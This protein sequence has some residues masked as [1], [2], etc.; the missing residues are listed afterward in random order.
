[1]TEALMSAQDISGII[2]TI[3]DEVQKFATANE[4]IAN[5]TNLLALNAT[6]EAARAGEYGKG[7]AVVASEVKQLAKQA[8]GNSK[9]FRN[10]VLKKISSQTDQLA[11]QFRE[12]EY[13]RL[14][15]MAQTLVQ[16]IVRNLYERTA[17]VRWWATDESL[18]HCLD[19]ITPEKVEHATKRM[20]LI[21]RFYSVYLNLLLT[22]PAGKVIAV[23]RPDKFPMVVGADVSSHY[24]FKG[25]INTQRGDEYV[26]DEI[27]NDPLHGGA[28][29]AAYSTAVRKD[30]EINGKVLGVLGVFFDWGEQSRVI[31]QDEP[32]LTQEEWKQSRVVL[33]DAKQRVIA[34]SDNKGLLMPF[35]LKATTKKGYYIDENGNT[36]AYAKTLG[37]QEFDGLGWSAAIIQKP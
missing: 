24:W 22:D 30:G 17:D 27:Y 12:G 3:Q 9:E 19:G 15:E 10:T 14:A 25:A 13:T 8:A 26:A 5:H 23:S 34:A 35:N 7:F 11:S 21:N 16:L 32:N 36:V 29:V 4:T 20:G 2:N 31:V 6:I 28:P 1:M 33:L 37:Y 18:Y